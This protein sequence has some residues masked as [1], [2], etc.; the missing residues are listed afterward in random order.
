MSSEETMAI[1]VPESNLEYPADRFLDRELSW[2]AFN[3][4]VLELAE[5]PKLFLLE[6]VNFLAIFASNLDEFFMVRV[7]G[8]KRRIATGLAVQSSSGLSPQEVLSEISREAHALQERHANVFIKDVKPALEAQGIRLVRWAELN[9]TEKSALHDYFQNQIFPVLTPLAVDPAHPFPYISGLSLN[10]AVVVQN[11]ETGKEHFARVKV[12][13]LLPRFV[14]I[15]GN[16]GVTDVRFVPLEEIIG[17]FLSLLFP[18]MQVL[19]HHTFR[20]TRNEDL[21]VDEDE[22]ENLLLALEKELLRRRFGPPVRLEVANDINP[23]IL[24][25]LVRELDI[26]E[27]DVY[28]LPSPLD[29]RGLFEISGIKRPE[30][31]Y[32]PHQVITNRFLQPVE[33]K[34][35]SIFSAMRQ[36]DIL[37]HHPYESFSTSVQA[38][39]QQAAA[40][41]KVLAIK[42]TLYRTS[43]DS[44]IV[45]ALIAA[46]EAGKQV[47]A[48]VEI[49]AR[50]DEQ[51]NI[52]WARKLEQA[53]VH[54]VYGIVGLKT[55]CKLALVIRQ[56]AGQLRRYCHVGTGNYNPKTARF[57]EDY[58][59]LTSRESVGEDLTKLFNQLSGYAPEAEFKSLLVSPNGV[60]DGLLERIDREIEFKEAGKDAR[61]R[62]KVNSLVDEQV[63]DALYKASKAGVKVEVL[64]RGMCALRP[65]VP[66]LSEN[67]TVRSVLGRYLEHSRVFTF[68]G[69][70]DPAVFIGSADMMHRNLD[71]RVEALVRLSQPDHIREMNAMF[72]LAMDDSSASWHLGPDGKWTRFKYD[73]DGANLVDV[74]YKIMAEVYAKRKKRS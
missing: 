33:D 36:R 55:H 16:T 53:G 64:V 5:D 72:D 69:G 22:G 30:L 15:P 62:V 43:G 29:L 7:A 10:L 13:P 11:P 63:I 52:A 4:R 66:G 41:P 57:Y 39:V 70:G 73:R 24:E 19:Q 8:L 35:V 71:R 38:F 14:R 51:N 44:P 32:P 74:Q 9:E 65:G 48:L 50:F 46:A 49:K 21:E 25:L 60:R 37:L 3:Q 68:L 47:L 28:N 61:V 54:V 23:Q 42:Q 27:E 26:S 1:S 12:P 45:D 40:D 17:E 18:G 6:R 34:D 59:L 58:G 67:I 31:H 2:L 20:V 56:E